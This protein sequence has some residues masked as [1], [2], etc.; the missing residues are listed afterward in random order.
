MHFISPKTDFGFKR[1]FGSPQSKNILISFLNALL[2]DG[3]SVIANLE[4]LD[5]YQMPRLYGLKDS[6][7]DVK[8]QLASGTFV[9][10][11]MQVIYL[12]GFE[13]RILYNAAKGYTIQLGTGQSYTMLLPVIALTI[14]D[15]TLFP[16]IERP[17]THFVLKERTDLLN[18]PFS[19]IELVFVE[20]P[21]FHKQIDEV[22]TLTEQWVSFFK[23]AREVRDIPPVLSHV[24]ELRQAFEIANQA[25]LTPEELDILEKKEAFMVDTRKTIETLERKRREARNK[26]RKEGHQEGRKKGQRDIARRMLATL[27]DETISQ[28]TGLDVEDI[29][30]LREEP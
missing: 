22:E 7:L 30:R 11:E 14:V 19:D 18:Y 21:K 23:Y 9:I 17:I 10:I 1:I 25:T 15:F 24:P 12:E 3:E 28:Y 4:I 5:P 29:R 26:G 27:D 6:F 13:K 20:L 2:Y 8:A 16:S